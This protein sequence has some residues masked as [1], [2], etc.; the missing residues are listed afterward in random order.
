MQT[1]M[2][3]VDPRTGCHV[4]PATPEESAEWERGNAGLLR[5][6]WKTVPVGDVLIEEYAGPGLWFGGAGF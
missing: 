2:M 1:T 6:F 4:R 5:P 3:A